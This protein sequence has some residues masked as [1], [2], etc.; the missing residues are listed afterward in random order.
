MII[1]A[2]IGGF[3]VGVACTGLALVAYAFYELDQ[4]I[5]RATGR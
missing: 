2:F 4:A 5:S 1:W 3:V